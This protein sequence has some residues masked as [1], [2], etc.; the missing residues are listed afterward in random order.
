MTEKLECVLD[1]MLE[2]D[3]QV[4]NIPK[5]AKLCFAIYEVAKNSKG[6]KTR[7]AKESSNNKD[8][9][10]NPIAWANTTV[11]DFRNQLKSGAMTLYMWAPTEEMN[12][13]ILNPLG[14]VVSNPRSNATAITII[15]NKLVHT[16]S[17]WCFLLN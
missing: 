14:T 8:I 17:L 6:T 13:E 9:Y 4:C 3:I 11:Y 2:F 5:S 16:H 15:F 7:R 12:D 10:H 1:E